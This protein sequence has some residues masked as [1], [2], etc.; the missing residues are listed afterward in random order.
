MAGFMDAPHFDN[1]KYKNNCR[2][3]IFLFSESL[4]IFFSGFI[5]ICSG[6]SYFLI[7]VSCFGIRFLIVDI[8][9]NVCYLE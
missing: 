1:E 2:S 6:I 3:L 7:I 9:R 8:Q 4:K 5:I